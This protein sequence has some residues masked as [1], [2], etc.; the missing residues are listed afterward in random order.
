MVEK[1]P[2]PEEHHP[3]PKSFSFQSI[4]ELRFL[5][6]DRTAQLIFAL[7]AAFAAGTIGLAWHQKKAKEKETTVRREESRQ[8]KITAAL[9]A[10]QARKEEL[11]TKYFEK[12]Q[13]RTRD[14][15]DCFFDL[16][17]LLYLNAEPHQPF[18]THQQFCEQYLRPFEEEVEESL[19]KR[20]K[21]RKPLELSDGPLP[22][23]V[24]ELVDMKLVLD[25]VLG[26]DMAYQKGMSSVIDP[27]LGKKLQCQS[28]TRLFVMMA[29]LQDLPSDKADILVEIYTEGHVLPGVLLADK[30]LYGIDMTVSGPGIKRFGPLDGIKI[31][32]RVIHA[33]RGLVQSVV[34]L[35]EASFA[36]IADKAV[37]KSS[38]WKA[39]E[40]NRGQKNP[41]GFGEPNGS[42]GPHPLPHQTEIEEPPSVGS[43]ASQAKEASG[44]YIFDLL[45]KLER[46]GRR[47]DA[48]VIREYYGHYRYFF[49]RYF[50]FIGIMRPLM[51][52]PS[53]PQE[54]YERI[55]SELERF[56]AGLEE[57]IEQHRIWKLKTKTFKILE[58]HGTPFPDCPYTIYEK[59]RAFERAAR[60]AREDALRGQ[61]SG[62]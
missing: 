55:V 28:G 9:E 49:D 56:F 30:S 53:V 18:L 7:W 25:D 12:K 45:T 58:Q 31:P 10:L 47:E 35:W 37:S 14:L 19:A 8:E 36:V 41:F 59:M 23:S 42:E 5:F 51:R 26:K 34:R 38:Q 27:I 60:K 32:I 17:W 4:S 54:E 22:E 16:E 40:E 61:N 21:E 15:V 11:A 2:P 33:E 46:E 13:I 3:P 44:H 62:E 48:Q 43:Q 50:D 52:N 57:Y 6:H 29:L 39:W 1:P 20:K 24:Q